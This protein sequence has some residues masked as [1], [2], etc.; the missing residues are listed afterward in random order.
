MHSRRIS[1]LLELASELKPR[2]LESFSSSQTHVLLAE[3]VKDEILSLGGHLIPHVALKLK[4]TLPDLLDNLLISLAIEGRLTAEEDVKDDTNTPDVTLL[5][6]G[7]F[8]D[9]RCEV[10]RLAKNTVHCVLFVNPTR[11]AKIDQLND[12]IVL[13]LKVDVL[14]LDVTMN[15]AVLV[16]VVDGT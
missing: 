8:D 7:A 14:W 5:R 10:V 9:L 1:L 11:S 16:E 12:G 6:V 4:L 15:D 3:H 2:V 13:V